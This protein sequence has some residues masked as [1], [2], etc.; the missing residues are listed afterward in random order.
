[1]TQIKQILNLCHKMIFSTKVVFSLWKMKI[2]EGI[3][4]K[5]FFVPLRR[6]KN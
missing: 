4:P 5:T 2:R 6:F 3:Y 1:M